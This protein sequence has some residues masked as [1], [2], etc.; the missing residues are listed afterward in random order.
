MTANDGDRMKNFVFI[1]PRSTTLD[2][3]RSLAG[4]GHHV[5]AFYTR[6]LYRGDAS[7]GAVE[8]MT[9]EFGRARNIVPGKIAGALLRH[10]EGYAFSGSDEG[11]AIS[12][13]IN[14]AR[15][16]VDGAACGTTALFNKIEQ[17]AHL[18]A[19]CPELAFE[20][21]AFAGPDDL[22]TFLAGQPGAVVVRPE[23]SR[24]NG[25]A[26]YHRPATPLTVRDV[27]PLFEDGARVLAHR[28]LDGDSYF[29]NGVV[30]ADR[31]SLT[32]CWQCFT[33]DSGPRR[34][35]TSVINL[36]DDDD[37]I[38]RLRPSLDRL[39]SAFGLRRGPVHFELVVHQRGVKVVK[40]VPRVAS[41]PLPTLCRLLEHP[42][43][44]SLALDLAQTDFAAKPDVVGGADAFVADYSFIA[45]RSGVLKAVRDWDRVRALG[46]YVA[47]YDYP[48]LD[49][50]IE[51]TV[52]GATYGATVLLKNHARD[53]LIADI[54]FC[55]SM[56][57]E[58]IF[59]I[60]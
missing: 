42:G 18:A 21:E 25:T 6:P 24:R 5:R 47:D 43:Q 12:H 19:T 34:L 7:L 52:C 16:L 22:L 31:L 49:A 10:S 51:R 8:D 54:E 38:A 9:G 48:E 29:V 33:L 57:E 3:A 37:V 59:E 14:A 27:E 30:C 40:C 4:C 36:R 17:H 13:A 32:D 56:N 45:R 60:A 28:F 44:A 2:L 58:S 39:V 11:L 15:G 46:S 20:A 53:A 23:I 35:L 26:L 41:E 50:P 1:D 55:Q